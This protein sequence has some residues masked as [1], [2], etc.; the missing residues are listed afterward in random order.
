VESE[1]E[2]GM[3]ER[4]AISIPFPQAVPYRPTI[5]AENCLKLTKDRCGLCEQICPT[6]AIRYEQEAVRQ[7]VDVGAV[8]LATGYDVMPTSKFAEYGYGEIEDV[9]T[10]LQFERINSASG[11]TGGDVLRPSDGKEAKELV[12]IQ[13][14]GSRDPEQHQPYCSKICCMYTA[15]HARLFKQKVPDGQAYVFYMDIRAGGK[16]YDEF[17]QR[18]I[19]DDGTLYFRGRVSKVF[20]EG[21]SVTVWGVDTLSDRRIELDADM[22]VLAS[23]IVPRS[24]T[25]E[26]ARMFKVG[27]GENGFLSE[28]H[29]KLRP[30]ESVTRGV[31][32]CGVCSGPRDIPDSVSQAGAAASKVLALFAGDEL[33]HP[34][35][36][37][38]VDE[39]ICVG[40][41]LCVSACPYDARE[42]DEKRGVATVNEILCHGCGA[43]AVA[44][45]NGATQVKNSS[46][47][48]LID[49]IDSIV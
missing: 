45:P 14:V 18:A 32:V 35:T 1:F 6:D 23:A 34:P 2:L 16:G 43:C 41:G 48:Q 49:M 36:V 27:V 10:S 26:L 7:Q 24:T 29:P 15:K 46:K 40:C 19:E 13:C 39:E 42:V 5:D 8:V 28:A 31:F 37:V 33:E 30:V 4:S 11:P 25:R 17:V 22:V 9:V 21:D 38:E 12:F 47:R 20:E 3:G 44:C